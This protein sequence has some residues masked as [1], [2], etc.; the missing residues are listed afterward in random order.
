MRQDA[1]WADYHMSH[2]DLLYHRTCS[3]ARR[4]LWPL[5]T[6]TCLPPRC[7]WRACVRRREE[8][9]RHGVAAEQLVFTGTADLE[10]HVAYKSAADLFLDTALYNAHSTAAD[11]LF[12]GV[13]MVP[14]S[15]YRPSR[16]SSRSPDLSTPTPTTF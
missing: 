9:E 10:V 6:S 4:K 5:L 13:P 7:V 16:S 14:V 12:A 8:A 1:G 2:R 15:L 11:V 3:L